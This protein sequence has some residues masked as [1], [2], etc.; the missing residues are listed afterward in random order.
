M[1]TGGRPLTRLGSVRVRF[2]FEDAEFLGGVLTDI[3]VDGRI[4]QSLGLGK[5]DS[6]DAKRLMSI[7]ESIGR[8]IDSESP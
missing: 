8:V 6:V 2:R 1:T 7:L 4:R 5:A 3:L